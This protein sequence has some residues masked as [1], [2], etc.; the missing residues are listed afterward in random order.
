MMDNLS[1]PIVKVQI[2]ILKI[3]SALPVRFVWLMLSQNGSSIDLVP[4]PSL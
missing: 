3:S 4:F 2:V 1:V